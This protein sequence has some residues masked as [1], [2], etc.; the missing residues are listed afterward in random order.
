MLNK[1]TMLKMFTRK[2]E[3]GNEYQN[4]RLEKFIITK[5]C[6]RDIFV[7]FL[8][9]GYETCTSADSITNGTVYDKTRNLLYGVANMDVKNGSNHILYHRWL[10]MLSRCYN[11]KNKS[12]KFYGAKGVIVCDQ[13]LKFS[14]YIHD[15]ERKDNYDKLLSNPK[16]W[17]IDKDIIG[18]CSNVYSNETTLI[19]ESKLNNL[20]HSIRQ[21]DNKTHISFKQ[22][23]KVCQYNSNGDIIKIFDSCSECARYLNVSLQSVC[24]WCN[25]KPCRK[26]YILKW[27]DDKHQG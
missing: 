20:E 27:F 9:T 24:N 17:Q 2:Y 5:R 23:K 10:Q 12:Y 21:L 14:N 6:H 19:V 13:W 22:M 8:K 3:V 1:N 4:K 26:G 11:E 15:I 16:Q 25:G 7:K 18:N